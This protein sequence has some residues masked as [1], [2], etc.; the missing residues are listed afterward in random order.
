MTLPS[1]RSSRRS[2]RPLAAL[3][4]GHLAEVDV[5]EV[6]SEQRVPVV[7][8]PAMLAAES[9]RR[10]GH[11]AVGLD[12]F[13]DHV[14]PQ[15]AVHAALAAALYDTLSLDDDAIPRRPVDDHLAAEVRGRI[16]SR[17]SP[18]DH[19]DALVTLAMTLAW[20]GKNDEA[21]RLCDA[22]LEKMPSHTGAARIRGRMLQKLDRHDEALEQLEAAARLAAGAKA[23][24]DWWRIHG[25][26]NAGD[27]NTPF[28]WWF[29]RGGDVQSLRSWAQ[30][31]VKD[32]EAVVAA[33]ARALASTGVLDEEAGSKRLA[34]IVPAER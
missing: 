17:I 12:F 2:T 22:C 4:K 23:L 27:E 9:R 28:Q 20:A 34:E 32:R 30:A 26:V 1:G 7:D 13:L 31:N 5:A 24:I 21:L 18:A 29:V 19:V 25:Y 15:I 8:F 10:H 33:V 6:A 14:H 11:E 3:L 16:L